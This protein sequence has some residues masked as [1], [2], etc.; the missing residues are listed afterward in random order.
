MDRNR[1]KGIFRHF[2]TAGSF[3]LLPS[4]AAAGPATVLSASFETGDPITWAVLKQNA[5]PVDKASSFFTGSNF[6]GMQGQRFLLFGTGSNPGRILFELS[7]VPGKSYTLSYSCGAT[8]TQRIPTGSGQGFAVTFSSI[9]QAYHGKKTVLS[10][11]GELVEID[12]LENL[13]SRAHPFA[14]PGEW[15]WR[16]HSWLPVSY[17]F[18]AK[19]N[20]ARI[21]F[22]T[23]LTNGMASVGVLD[24]VR[25]TTEPF[26][27]AYPVAAG[28]KVDF[29]GKLEESN[30]L[31]RW[32]EIVPQPTSPLLV[33]PDGGSRFFR[34]SK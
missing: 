8:D 17:T 32:T 22:E 16:I 27:Q 24:Q 13:D 18:V 19:S 3:V 23:S 28:M 7:T 26:A 5:S 34:V 29:A 15:N 4:T 6:D 31:M 9:V 21:Q 14:T 33:T 30:D 2:A 1:L 25:V 12:D 11:L 20:T 10:H